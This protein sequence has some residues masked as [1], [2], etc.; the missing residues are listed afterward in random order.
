MLVACP[1]GGVQSDKIFKTTVKSVL[2]SPY[3]W[4]E[5]LFLFYIATEPTFLGALKSGIKVLILPAG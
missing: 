2:H 1:E 4:N 3:S 5:Q